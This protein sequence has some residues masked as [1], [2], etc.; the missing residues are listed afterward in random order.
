VSK[1]SLC[2]SEWTLTVKEDLVASTRDAILDGALHVMQTRG[3]ART[4]TKEI[5]KAAG[6]SEATLYKLFD[7]KFDLFLCVL[8][9]RLPQVGVVSNGAESLAGTGSVAGN[10]HRIVV[11]MTSFYR[12]VLPVGMSIFSDSGLLAR[13]RDAVRSRGPGPEVISEGVRAY[14]G[15]EQA[16][17]RVGELAPIDGAALALAGACMHQAFLWCFDGE[18]G[19]AATQGPARVDAFAAG[20]VAAILPALSSARD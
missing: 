15:A 4:T 2:Y 14:L 5:A 16:A 6:F 11:E 19:D 3:L 8:A 13:H 7:D 18:A 12:A 9:E 17:G 1:Y 20:V 10:L